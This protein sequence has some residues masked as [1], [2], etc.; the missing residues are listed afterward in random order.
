MTLTGEAEGL[1]E[2]PIPLP[3]SHQTFYMFYRNRTRAFAVRNRR[4]TPSAITRPTPL[5]CVSHTLV[6]CE[7]CAETEEIGTVEHQTSYRT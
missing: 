7:I 2:S 6:P 5:P 1:G 4:L 3:L